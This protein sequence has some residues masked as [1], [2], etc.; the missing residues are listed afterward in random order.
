MLSQSTFVAGNIVEMFLFK[1]V[2]FNSATS[3]AKTS[4]SE[5]RNILH[6]FYWGC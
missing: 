4:S 6:I 3:F 5:F 2:D 1:N